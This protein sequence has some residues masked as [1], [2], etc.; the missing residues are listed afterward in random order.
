M[1][2]PD[3]TLFPWASVIRFGLGRLR[4]PPD[5]FWRLSV[6]ELSALTG[7]AEAPTLTNR[8]GLEALMALFPDT[9]SAKDKTDDR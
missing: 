5:Q 2:E 6:P 8:Q 3:R 4:L 1:T 9:R 7:A